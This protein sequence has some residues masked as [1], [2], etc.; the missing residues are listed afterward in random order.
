[1]AF[2]RIDNQV[3]IDEINHQFRNVIRQKKD[4]FGLS[5]LREI[6]KKHDVNGNG[7]LDL[8]EFEEALA[9]FG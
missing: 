9:S 3:R 7:K 5:S 1:M 4:V 6:F 2:F 8:V